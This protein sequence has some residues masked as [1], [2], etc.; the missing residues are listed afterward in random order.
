MNDK[1]PETPR[2]WALY[3]TRLACEIGK[4]VLTGKTRPPQ[5]V[6][7]V[8]YALYALFDAVQELAGLVDEATKGGAK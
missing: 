2:E 5:G 8:E 4:D 3:R 6:P 1:K 7:I